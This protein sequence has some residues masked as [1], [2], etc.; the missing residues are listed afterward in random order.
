MKSRFIEWCPG[1]MTRYFCYIAVVDEG[2]E[3]GE[4]TVVLSWLSR[5]DTGGSCMR[6]NGC[7]LPAVGYLGEKMHV[8][9][10]DGAALLALLKH[11]CGINV[12]MPHGYDDMGRPERF[13]SEAT[14]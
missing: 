7:S 3:G 14:E 4:P 8:N 11:E 1:N 10:A 6:V 12:I 9:I 2:E 13:Q 5:G